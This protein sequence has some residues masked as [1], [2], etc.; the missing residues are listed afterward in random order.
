M[1]VRLQEHLLDHGRGIEPLLIQELRNLSPFFYNGVSPFGVCGTQFQGS[2]D[3]N[4]P[5]Q[6]NTNWGYDFTNVQAGEILDVSWSVNADHGGVYQFRLCDD[7][8]LVSFL[9]A[10]EAPNVT[11][12]NELEECYQ[13]GILRCDDVPT[14]DCSF[15]VDCKDGWGCSTEGLYFH[16]GDSSSTYACAFHSDGT[17]AYGGVLVQ[18]KVLIP[19]NFPTGPTVLTWRWDSHETTEVFAAC[20]DITITPAANTPTKSPN[21]A[22]TTEPTPQ[23]DEDNEDNEDTEDGVESYCCWWGPNDDFCSPCGSIAGP[24]NWCAES[25]ERCE[26]CSGTWCQG[27]TQVTPRPTSAPYPKPTSAPV[28]EPTVS[29]TPEK[30]GY[31]GS[32]DLGSYCCFRGSCLDKCYA[33]VFSSWYCGQSADNCDDCNGEWCSTNV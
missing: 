4:F 20:A 19:R 9:W 31:D 29:P 33:P 8:S 21:P 30:D 10:D 7:P 3:Y 28:P 11:I 16:C 1:E 22:P 14:N 23:D 12:Q 32:D 6:V 5:D 26:H 17:R 2:A 25:Q 27:N 13:A 24:D 15:E 18:R